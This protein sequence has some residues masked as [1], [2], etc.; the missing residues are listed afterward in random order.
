MQT[1]QVLDVRTKK[2][3]KKK[4]KSVQACLNSLVAKS[5][6]PIGYWQV[7]RRD[8]LWELFLAS[9]GSVRVDSVP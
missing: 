3:F 2:L 6:A 9:N 7:F 8:R 1:F 4:A 5:D